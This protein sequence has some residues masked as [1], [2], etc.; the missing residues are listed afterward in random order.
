[1][2][3]FLLAPV[4][5]LVQLIFAQDRRPLF[6]LADEHL[7]M[8]ADLNLDEK[9]KDAMGKLLLQALAMFVSGWCQWM[10]VSIFNDCT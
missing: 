9:A 10:A 4:K 5:A 8:F 2:L 6:E 3:Y 7:K 1:M